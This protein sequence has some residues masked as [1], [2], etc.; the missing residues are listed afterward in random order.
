M[1]FIN[2]LLKK[3]NK[4]KVYSSFKDNIW[5][6][7]LADMQLLSKFNKGFRFLL[8]LIDIFSKYAWIIPLKDKKGISIVN[9]CQIILKEPKRKPNKI[10]VD[11]RSE[12]CNNSFKKWLKDND[13]EMY[14][15]NNEGKSVVAE[16][17]IRTLKNNIYKYMTSISKNVYID[18]LDDIVKK[19]N[20][21]YHAS[22]K[23]KPVDVKDNTYIGFK[24]EVNDKNR[25]FKVGDQLR[26]PKYKNIFA[27]GYMPNW[28]EEIFI[29][30]TIENTVPWTYV[31]N[32]LNGEEI[33]GT[34]YENELQKTNQKEFRIEKVL[35]KKGDKL[36][37]KWKGYDNSFN[38]WIDCIKYKMSQY[39]PK[40]YEPF[41]GD[42]N[43]TVDLS[44]YATKDDIKNITHVDTSSFALKTNLA[45]LKT[46]VDKLYIDKLATVPVDLSKL[47]NVVKNDVI[48]KTVY[49]KLVVKVDNI[50]T[51]GLVKKTDYNRKISEIED[52]IPDSSSFVKKTDYNTKI[53]EIEDKIPDVSGLATQTALATVGNKIPSISGLAKKNRLQY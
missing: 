2:Q 16:R 7:H 1:N 37:V 34:F 5:G 48:K 15:T 35:K 3:F 44:N 24:K 27:K 49:D 13:I 42:I 22:I 43:V 18:K 11:K 47:S 6:V 52:K 36:Y 41:G 20:N 51:S 25:K 39:F 21:T 40:P 33:I 10:W 45:N 4:R 17:F 19:Y 32:D 14:S 29:I 38:S 46:E 50:D 9:R 28:S 30:K 12:F 53:T 8:C 26:I 31:I 23:M